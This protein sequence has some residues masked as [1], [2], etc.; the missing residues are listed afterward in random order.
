MIRISDEKKA[1]LA[2]VGLL[3]LRLA[4]GGCIA[5]HGFQKLS[6]GVSNFAAGLERNGMPAPEIMAWLSVLSEWVGGI[7]I[8]VGFLTRLAAIPLV[9]NMAVAV[10]LVHRHAYFLPAGMEYALNLGVTYLVIAL[11]GPGK[12]SLDRLIFAK[13]T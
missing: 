9:I 10:L 5:A 6:D 2:N 13:Q 11:L 3:L 4:V 7:F 8:A 12:F 1:C